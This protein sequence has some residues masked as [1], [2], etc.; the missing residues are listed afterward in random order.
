MTKKQS[1]VSVVT[2]LIIMAAMVL[3]ASPPA[4]AN[5]GVFAIDRVGS[6]LGIDTAGQIQVQPKAGKGTTF[7]A[8]TIAITD[9]DSLTIAG[10]IVPQRFEIRLGGLS[11]TSASG[12]QVFIADRA[13]QVTAIR[14]VQ[15]AQGGSGCV[16][17]VEKLTGT[18]APGSGTVM[19]TASYNCN[20]TANNTV[21]IYALTA[22]AA[23]LQLAAGDRLG[24]KLGGTLTALAGLNITV[25]LKAI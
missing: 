16:A 20:S 23:T 1:L 18:T 10:V 11:A 14:V 17:D 15:R 25:Q 24:A 4:T 8:G 2:A 12:D 9:A 5:R 21:T 3:I 13:Y 22:T 19:G 7:A 6:S